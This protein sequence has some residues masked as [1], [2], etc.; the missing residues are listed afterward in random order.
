MRLS[1]GLELRD[2]AHW[3]VVS[4]RKTTVSVLIPLR[5]R[6][7]VTV[8]H[9]ALEGSVS[10]HRPIWSRSTPSMSCVCRLNVAW[11]RT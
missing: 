3:D 11:K 2:E 5:V 6:S 9:A 8:R 1:A 4:L 10:T 7:V